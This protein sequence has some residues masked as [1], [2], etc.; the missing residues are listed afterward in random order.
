MQNDHTLLSLRPRT[1]FSSR[2]ENNAQVFDALVDRA[3]LIPS[4]QEAFTQSNKDRCSI[5]WTY[6]S[7]HLPGLYALHPTINNRK[8]PFRSSCRAT[9]HQ[10]SWPATR[11]GG[12]WNRPSRCAGPS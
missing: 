10:P 5:I 6:I 8:I 9:R 4:T 2:S 12:T 1:I 7:I 11:S 3:A